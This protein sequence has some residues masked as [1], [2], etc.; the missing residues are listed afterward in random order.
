MSIQYKSSDGWKNISSSSNNAVATKTGTISCNI[1]ITGA[2]IIKELSINGWQNGNTDSV[3][4]YNH[5]YED[6]YICNCVANNAL[7]ARLIAL[8]SW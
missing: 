3:L 8:V 2:T 5:L 7:M 6:F 4:G 1:S